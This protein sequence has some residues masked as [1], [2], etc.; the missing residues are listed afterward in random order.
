MWTPLEILR[1][2]KIDN[3]ILEAIQFSAAKKSIFITIVSF[4]WAGKWDWDV[5]VKHPD[6]PA[7]A[8]R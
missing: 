4:V 1:G 8:T 7:R 2:K 3:R 6:D 5:P